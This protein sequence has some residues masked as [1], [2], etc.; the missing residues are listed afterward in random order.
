MT[1]GKPPKSGWKPRGASIKQLRKLEARHTRLS[2]RVRDM[3]M[4]VL[5][6][7]QATYDD[8][9]RGDEEE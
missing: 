9:Q 2:G 6:L 1:S 7:E 3:R 4:R 8:R 5:L